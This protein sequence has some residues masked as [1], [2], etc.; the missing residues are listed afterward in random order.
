[1]E[2]KLLETENGKKNNRMDISS[3]K[4]AKFHIKMPGRG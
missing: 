1:M 2:Q 4:Q 3:D